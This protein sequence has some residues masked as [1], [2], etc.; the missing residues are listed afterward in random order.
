MVFTLFSYAQQLLTQPDCGRPRLM[1]RG[2]NYMH[3]VHMHASRAMSTRR[4]TVEAATVAFALVLIDG[5]TRPRECN[6]ASN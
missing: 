2:C 6:K 1:P 3:A 4:W 5:G